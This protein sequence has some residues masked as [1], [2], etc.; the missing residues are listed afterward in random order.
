MAKGGT[1]V[2]PSDFQSKRHHKPT[3]RAFQ[4]SFT[5]G[6]AHASAHARTKTKQSKDKI[7]HKKTT[8]YEKQ[9]RKKQI[10]QRT[11]VR[12]NTLSPRKNC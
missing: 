3:D 4:A 2:P 8:D 5:R 6:Q 9:N 1:V 7:N 11:A 12:Q 10:N